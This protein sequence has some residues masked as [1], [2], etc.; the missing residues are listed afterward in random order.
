VKY[1]YERTLAT[2][3]YPRCPV[4]ALV[5]KAGHKWISATIC[6]GYAEATAEFRRKAD[7]LAH[8]SGK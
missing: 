6:Q 7:A 2:R 1:A 4:E 3:S 8:A 5:Y